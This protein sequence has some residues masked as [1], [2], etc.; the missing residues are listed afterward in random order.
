M[1]STRWSVWVAH[2]SRWRRGGLLNRGLRQALL[3]VACVF[4]LT[5]GPQSK[6]VWDQVQDLGELRVATVNGPF[7]VYES[8]DGQAGFE[9]ELVQKLAE[10]FRLSIDWQVFP[11]LGQAM[12]EVAMGNAHLLAAAWSRPETIP[13]GLLLTSFYRQAPYVLACSAKDRHCRV[14]LPEVGAQELI[15][16]EGAPKADVRSVLPQAILLRSPQPVDFLLERLH[17][18]LVEPL[19]VD[20]DSLTLAQRLHP[21]LR[22]GPALGPPVAKVWAVPSEGG[23]GLHGRVQGY[24]DRAQRSGY[25]QRL[26]DRHFKHLGRL[27]D[28]SQRAFRQR[29]DSRL[30]AFRELFEQ[31]GQTYGIDWRFLAAMAYQESAWDADA[32]SPTGVR[33]LMMLTRATAREVGVRQRTDPEQSIDGGARY[34]LKLHSRV[35]P[36]APEPDRTW[37]TL[38][39]YNLGFG[40]FLD[41]QRLTRSLGGNDQSWI[42]L[43]A[44]LPKLMQPRW[45][46]TL[47]HGYARG[48]EARAYVGN[49]R[50]YFDLLRWLYPLPGESRQTDRPLLEKAVSEPLPEPSPEPVLPLL[51]PA[52]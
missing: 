17:Q 16:V 49:I 51:L 21:S 6:D 46:Q 4:W 42:D 11:D 43:R 44:H 23:Q 18:D 20:A 40:H 36:G 14:D 29:V 33:G 25:L 41:L 7:T 8:S 2:W 30:P 45:Y 3:G 48:T 34:F 15:L 31:A 1:F 5:A 12:E 24:L 47:R 13:P 38:A 28:Y 37:M 32:V 27:D 22:T 35:A 9:F 10:E 19:V 26:E 52:M 50:A 39:S